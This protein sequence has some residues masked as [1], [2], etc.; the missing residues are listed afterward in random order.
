MLP[1][2]EMGISDSGR[3]ETVLGLKSKTKQNLKKK[4]HT[5]SSSKEMNRSSETRFLYPFL[6]DYLLW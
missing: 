6:L 4:P 2:I 5:Y 3:Y 1:N